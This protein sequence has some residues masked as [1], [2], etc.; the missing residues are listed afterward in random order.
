MAKKPAAGIAGPA[1]VT[2]TLKNVGKS[3][4]LRDVAE[5][6]RNQVRG[7]ADVRQRSFKAKVA[8]LEVDIKGSAQDLADELES[9]TYPGFAVEIDEVTANTVVAVV[10]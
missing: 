6:L 2:L 5:I 7:V 1:S 4:F 9:K 3:K 10:K 8:E